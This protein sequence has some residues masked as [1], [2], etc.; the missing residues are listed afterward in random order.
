[1]PIGHYLEDSAKAFPEKHA[2]VCGSERITYRALADS[3]GSFGGFLRSRGLKTGD[4]VA[5]FL[6]N[7][8]ELV[9]AIFGIAGSGGVL[10]QIN[11]LAPPERVRYILENCQPRFLVAPSER[12]A[13]IREAEA[14]LATQPAHI[15]TGPASGALRYDEACRMAPPRTAEDAS[16]GDLA[17]IVYTSGSTGKPK[18]AALTHRNFDVVT[19]TVGEYL[20]HG[21]EDIILS[22]LPLSITYGLMQLLVTFR[23]AGTLVLEKGFGYPYEFIS[24]LKK[25][26]IT[27]FA[28]VPTVYSLLAHMNLDHEAFPSLRYIT[29]AAAAMPSAFIPRLREIFPTTKIFLMHGM[30][31]CLRTTYLPPEE[32]TRRPTSVGR[33]M[34]HVELWLED[35]AGR[36]LGPGEVGE[37]IIRGPNIMR[38]YWNDPEATAKI[39][40]QDPATG[41]KVLRSG[42]LFRMDGDGYFHF[43]SRTDDVIKCRGLK[44]SP[45]E[46]ED[47]IYQISDVMEVR[48]LGVPDEVLGQAIRAEV[49]LKKG[50]VCTTDQI[51]AHCLKHLEEFKVPKFVE[52]VTSLPKTAGGKIKR[53]L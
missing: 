40:R 42:D 6:E 8:P 32:L 38:G 12:L 19:E 11:P 16:E 29:N 43:V 27:G 24:R 48:A 35:A 22:F 41:E 17:A 36:R 45:L 20:G 25:E 1:M 18:G 21:P 53:T 26:R 50:A 2:L 5:T 7:G 3:A 49:V 31:E 9:V 51:K 37:L 15:L 46:V 44:V 52:L 4:R 14:S 28:G 39:L 47:V 34:N 33:G 23:T 10:V 30:T 13:Q